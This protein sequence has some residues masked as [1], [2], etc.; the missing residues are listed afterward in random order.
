[1]SD[2]SQQL[3]REKLQAATQGLNGAGSVALGLS[4]LRNSYGTGHG[5][6]SLRSGLG[7][8]HAAL[9]VNAARLWCEMMLTTF[10]SESA[11]WRF[12]DPNG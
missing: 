11:P 7:Q 4:E 6:G 2:R 5:P 1:M 10:S 12:E 3:G 8:R 9:A